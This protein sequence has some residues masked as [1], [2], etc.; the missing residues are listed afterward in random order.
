MVERQARYCTSADGTRIAYCVFG[1]GPAFVH[2][3]WYG[4]SFDNDVD[5]RGVME[6]IWQGRKVIQYDFRGVGAIA[7]GSAVVRRR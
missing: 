5:E 6:P 4:N 2:C 7:A 3:P 1:E